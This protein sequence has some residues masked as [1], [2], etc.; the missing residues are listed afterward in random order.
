MALGTRLVGGIPLYLGH[1]RE[2]AETK[3][4]E[5]RRRPALAWEF[6]DAGCVEAASAP[7][8]STSRTLKIP[9]PISTYGQTP[10]QATL[11]GVAKSSTLARTS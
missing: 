7:A 4:F 5:W 1:G 3:D 11:I 2:I 8:Q 6:E 9:Q 10:L